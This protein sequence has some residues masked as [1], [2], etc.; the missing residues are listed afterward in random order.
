[1]SARFPINQDNLCKF[2]AL[3][4]DTYDLDHKALGAKIRKLKLPLLHCRSK[5]GGAHLVLVPERLGASGF[6]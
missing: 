2:G 5:S 4:I 3:D 6:D 1:V